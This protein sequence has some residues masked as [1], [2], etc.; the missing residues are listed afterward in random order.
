MKPLSY[1]MTP[2]PHNNSASSAQAQE[3]GMVGFGQDCVFAYTFR[4]ASE[5]KYFPGSGHNGEL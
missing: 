3:K 2:P 4:K 5:E 1:I